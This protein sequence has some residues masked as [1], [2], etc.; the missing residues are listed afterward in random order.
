MKIRVNK[1]EREPSQHMGK[2][3]SVCARDNPTRRKEYILRCPLIILG[4]G[5]TPPDTPAKLIKHFLFQGQSEKMQ[6]DVRNIF[7]KCWSPEVFYAAV[8]LC[9]SDR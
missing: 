4:L 9:A 2:P 3:R 6:V 8:H 5:L 1:E 7:A